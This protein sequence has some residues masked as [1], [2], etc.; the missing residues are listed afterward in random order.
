VSRENFSQWL[1]INYLLSSKLLLFSMLVCLAAFAHGDD[2]EDYKKIAFYSRIRSY[3][4]N[5]EYSDAMVDCIISDLRRSSLYEIVDKHNLDNRL[6]RDEP[7]KKKYPFE[8]TDKYCEK[9]I[10]IMNI[11]YI[12]GSIVI[13]IAVIATICFYFRC[14]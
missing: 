13:L 8:A 7:S 9:A 11:V 1:C 2:E 4:T 14:K 10:L 5:E 3:Y 12:V 6:K